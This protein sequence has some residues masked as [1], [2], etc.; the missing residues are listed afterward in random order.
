M[1]SRVESG[2]CLTLDD[3]KQ[4]TLTVF[5]VTHPNDKPEIIRPGTKLDDRYR[6]TDVKIP[7]QEGLDVFREIEERWGADDDALYEQ[8]VG[9][10]REVAIILGYTII[11]P[12]DSGHLTLF[13]LYT[14]Y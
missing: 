11:K 7:Y 13:R 4:N 12:G 2:V 9:G 1:F 14:A 6:A 8:W 3:K 5:S 10:Q